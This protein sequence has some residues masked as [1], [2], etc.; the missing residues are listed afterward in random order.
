MMLLPITQ[1]QVLFFFRVLCL[2]VISAGFLLPSQ[3]LWLFQLFAFFAAEDEDTPS[4]LISGC[5]WLSWV[6]TVAAITYPILE[7]GTECRRLDFFLTKHSFHRL[8]KVVH[9]ADYLRTPIKQRKHL[10]LFIQQWEEFKSHLPKIDVD[11]RVDVQSPGIDALRRMPYEELLDQYI[12]ILD[13]YGEVQKWF[14]KLVKCD[15]KMSICCT[16]SYHSYLR[17]VSTSHYIY[18][19][20]ARIRPLYAR[21]YRENRYLYLKPPM[22]SMEAARDVFARSTVWDRAWVRPFRQDLDQGLKH[23]HEC[24]DAF[25][26]SECGEANDDKKLELELDSPSEQGASTKSANCSAVGQT[27]F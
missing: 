2:A 25:S 27:T 23:F 19:C 18:K 13:R 1:F 22:E 10:K 6:W 14:I 7:D 16:E 3:I 15:S 5:E 26:W 20:Y 4:F 11:T 9:K 21:V 8:A 24:L 17:T 12:N